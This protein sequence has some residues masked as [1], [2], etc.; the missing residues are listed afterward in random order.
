M[1]FSCL[2]HV[3]NYNEGKTL[4]LLAMEAGLEF[5]VHVGCHD[6]NPLDRIDFAESMF[7]L[8]DFTCI[9]GAKYELP[10]PGRAPA[11]LEGSYVV[12]K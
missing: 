3:Y 6:I 4:P 8:I 2:C 11:R 10:C 7:K 1:A 9:E 12:T 5:V